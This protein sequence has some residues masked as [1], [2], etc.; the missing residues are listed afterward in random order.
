MTLITSLAVL[1][2]YDCQKRTRLTFFFF[3]AAHSTDGRDTKSFYPRLY[4]GL[5]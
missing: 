2:V 3:I 5:D 4:D 1:T